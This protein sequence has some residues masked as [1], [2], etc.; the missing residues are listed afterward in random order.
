MRCVNHAL[1]RCERPS[2]VNHFLPWLPPGVGIAIIIELCVKF[3]FSVIWACFF[4][5]ERLFQFMLEVSK[6]MGFLRFS[7]ASFQARFS[8]IFCI[9]FRQHGALS[10]YCCCKLNANRLQRK[11]G[12][13][14]R[15]RQ[16]W[17]GTA[18]PRVSG[19]VSPCDRRGLRKVVRGGSKPEDG[20][21]R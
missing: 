10:L 11:L 8:E 3:S 15:L 7:E 4:L 5:L 20:A 17:P 2:H 9:C 21:A 12:Q 18:C 13:A 16:T 6:Q 19:E 1:V 14:P